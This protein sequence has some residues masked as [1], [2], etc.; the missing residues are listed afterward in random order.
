MK[1]LHIL[2]DARCAMCRR[3]KDWLLA[4]PSFV[5]LE[6]T[7]LQ[8]PQVK[9]RFPGV[10]ALHPEENII[11]I[12]DAGEVWQGVDAWIMCLWALQE[13]RE[14]SARLAHPL[15]KPFARRTCELVSRNRHAL[16]RWFREENAE[17][18]AAHL[19]SEPRGQDCRGGVCTH[20]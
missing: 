13:Y 16:S 6:F 2:Y 12:S 10:E 18:L 4:Q 5:R 1:T 8:D 15:L 19:A 9:T 14:W 7:A 3:C 17:G 11:V 20:S